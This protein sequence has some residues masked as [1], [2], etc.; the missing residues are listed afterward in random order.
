MTR[1]L[2]IC[3]L[4]GVL[5]FVWPDAGWAGQEFD[6]LQALAYSDPA[7]ALV[8][9]D[10]A[11]E[12]R[13]LAPGEADLIVAR[14]LYYQNGFRASLSRLARAEPYFSEDRLPERYAVL[15]T[16]VAQNYYRIGSLE[17]AM[18]AA[19]EAERIAEAMDERPVLAQVYNIIAA[20]YVASAEPE[21]A[22]EYFQRA[23]RVFEA[24]DSRPDIAKL[25]NN[26]GVLYIEIGEFD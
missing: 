11:S 24:L 13:T 17:Q 16:L 20:V 7:A 25:R 3:L 9:A 6:Q 4:S 1:R 26:L 19:R 22:R 2:S 18:I 15:R 12:A 21:P 5:A 14:A 8:Q 23:L 10:A